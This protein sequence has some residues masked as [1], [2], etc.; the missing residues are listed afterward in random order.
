MIYIASDHAGYNR[1]EE[2]K[3]FLTKKEICFTDLGPNN[4][5]PVNYVDYAKK[6]CKKVKLDNNNKGILI[7]GSGTG[8]VIAANRNKGIRAAMCY[9]LYSAEMSRKDN[10]SNIICLRARKF[11]FSITRKIIQKWLNTKFSNLIRHKKR[12]KTLD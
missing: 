9:D 11:P 7:C 6:V 4:S 5:L 8:M 3:T 1:K 10:N 2:I 12:I